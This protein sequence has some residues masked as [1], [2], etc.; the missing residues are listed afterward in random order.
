MGNSKHFAKLEQTNNLTAQGNE[1]C[2]VYTNE[3]RQIYGQII[4]K[5]ANNFYD[6]AMMNVE[7]GKT[8]KSPA[9]AAFS[10]NPD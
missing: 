4:D 7:R 5:Y 3:I 1:I 10:Y 9:G 6:S 8:G 2:I